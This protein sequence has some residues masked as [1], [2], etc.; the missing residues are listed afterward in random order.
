[1]LVPEQELYRPRG[2]ESLITK[3]ACF[4]NSQEPGKPV[5]HLSVVE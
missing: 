4:G 3:W 2:G 5:V 1:M